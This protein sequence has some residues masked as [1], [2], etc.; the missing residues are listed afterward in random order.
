MTSCERAF[1][2]QAYHDGELTPADRGAVESHLAECAECRELLDELRDLS[3]M[4]SA[5][6]MAQMPESSRNR[7]YGVWWKSRSNSDRSV[8]RITGWLTAAAAAVLAIGL[9]RAPG[10]A[11]AAS[12]RVDA[13]ELEASAV[14]PAD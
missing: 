10:Q 6:A 9:L 14:A 3:A 13:W 4:F 7:L 8:R 2:V 12:A 1:Q 11:P 5:A